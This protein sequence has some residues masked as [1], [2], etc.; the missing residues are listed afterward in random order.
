MRRDYPL[1]HRYLRQF[2]Q[3]LV[4]RAAYR[5]YQGRHAFYS[6]YNVGEYTLAR[7]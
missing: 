4:A 1:T 6:M 5:R 7:G 3:L 2:E